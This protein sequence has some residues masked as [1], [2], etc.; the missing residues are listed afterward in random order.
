MLDQI[1]GIEAT[2][3]IPVDKTP[4][5]IELFSG[6]DIPVSAD[7]VSNSD[8]HYEEQKTRNG[9]RSAGAGGYR[10][11][12]FCNFMIFKHGQRRCY[13]QVVFEQRLQ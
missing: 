1:L 11:L 5:C 6:D 9:A 12:G 4:H 8:K 13:R 10:G 3:V 7:S 2:S